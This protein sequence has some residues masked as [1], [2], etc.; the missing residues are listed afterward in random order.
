MNDNHAAA[1]SEFSPFSRLI[2]GVGICLLAAATGNVLDDVWRPLWAQSGA[3]GL[4]AAV[5]LGIAGKRQSAQAEQA[6]DSAS[7]ARAETSLA[8]VTQDCATIDAINDAVNRLTEHAARTR[9]AQIFPPGRNERPRRGPML[10]GQPLAIT[11]LL[12]DH[13]D[14][15]DPATAITTSGSLRQISSRRSPS[16]IRSRSAVPRRC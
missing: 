3:F 2:G 1:V 9:H 12:D 15:F 4:V 11:S 6:R 8:R 10:D 16:N 14:G 7:T 13:A 5:G